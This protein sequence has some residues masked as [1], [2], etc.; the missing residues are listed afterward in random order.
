MVRKL[1]IKQINQRIVNVSK[2]V[3]LSMITL[4]STAVLAA[5]LSVVDNS[6]SPLLKIDAPEGSTFDLLV[7]FKDSSKAQGKNLIF[8]SDKGNSKNLVV[9]ESDATK[10]LVISGVALGQYSISSSSNE[11]E[12]RRV[13]VVGD[14]NKSA[15]NKED[16]NL[17]PVAYTAGAAAIAGT[18]A[19]VGSNGNGLDIFGG[20]SNSS[21]ARS[22]SGTSGS[23]RG[24]GSGSN[25]GGTVTVN[26]IILDP[27]YPSSPIA[28]ASPVSTISFASP[29]PTFAANPNT[30]GGSSNNGV[31][32]PTPN[33]TVA[34]AP[35]VTD[36]MTPS[37]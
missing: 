4:T 24:G 36:P 22:G 20:S 23:V 10:G 31:T 32:L 3:A 13:D 17:A 12:I 25:N 8:S 29:A 28:I 1:D 18:A 37:N 30:G 11:V 14:A 16:S 33:P 6:G 15:A 27:N 5:E 35:P 21:S 26:N 7:S 34:P 19:V 9:T 2:L